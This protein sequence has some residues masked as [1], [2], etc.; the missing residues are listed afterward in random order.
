MYTPEHTPK[1]LS[2]FLLALFLGASASFAQTGWRGTNAGGDGTSWGSANN[3]TNGVPTGS[4]T[5]TLSNSAPDAAQT[6]NLGGDRTIFSGGSIAIGSPG[7]RDYTIEGGK[8]I[9]ERNTSSAITFINNTAGS[10]A[11]TI[12]SDIQFKTSFATN[13]SI[14][15]I[16]GANAS[17]RTINLNG[18]I[19][20]VNTN[21]GEQLHVNSANARVN[22]RG[23]N[24]FFTFK[25]TAGEV[26]TY[27]SLATGGGQLQ[28]AGGTLSL[29]SDL[30][31]GIGAQIAT[32]LTGPLRIRLREEA[33]S[34]ADRTITFF[35]RTGS[36]AGSGTNAYI[37]IIDN[38]NSTGRVILNL[39]ANSATN[40]A[41]HVPINLGSTGL[42][43]FSQP[44]LTYYGPGNS[45]S[46]IISGAGDVEKIGTGTTIL[47]AVNT[48][49][50][51]T[52]VS[53]GALVLGT[54]N[55]IG[56]SA[57]IVNGGTLN[58]SNTTATVASLSISSGSVTGV[59]GSNKLTATTYDLTGGTVSANLGTGT[60]RANSGSA[61]LSGTADA[62]TVNVG[63]GALTL[64][65]AGRLASGAAVT[66]SNSGSLN[67]G[68]N[69]T[70]GSFLISGG[71]LSGSSL[72]TAATYDLTGGT[73]SANLG[74]GTLRANS[75]SATLNGTSAATTVNIGGGALTLGSANRLAS[76][77]TVTVSNSGSLILGGN[78]TVSSLVLSGGSLGGSGV[79]SASTYDFQGGTVTANLGSGT[80]TAST[81]TTLING[82]L[83]GSLTVNSGATLGGSGSIGGA[84][85][86]NGNL[87]PGN[88]PGLL[89]FSNNLT[90]SSSAVTTMEING[91]ER[92]VSYDGIDV[93]GSLIYGGRLTLSLGTTFTEVGQ[94][95]F[96]LFDFSGNSGSFSIVELIGSYTGSLT[97]NSGVWGLNSDNETWSF[98]QG[99][100][101]LT[102]DVVP[103]PSTYAMLVL[104]AA[105]LAAHMI[106]RR[107]RRQ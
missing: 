50:G 97:N 43:R 63:G 75:G 18:N 102:L 84:T 107:H 12:N 10:T 70:V 46:G 72:L 7:N 22:I 87:Q 101:V 92:G 14:I 86:I 30:S 52:T 42:L 90:L 41:Q 73:V 24:S 6:I 68:G 82:S 66:I 58:M 47:T 28:A 19:T 105:G 64:G 99:D 62:T 91:L 55:A 98:S 49:T 1:R 36:S 88:S 104:S 106:R 76:G 60:L 45:N 54:N 31:I 34:S 100:G 67:L 5:I 96:N 57:V 15:T 48:Y 2:A 94:Y 78:Q 21:V 4:N 8:L 11:L 9:L 56:A 85:T 13:A 32:F 61:T 77:S 40:T 83:A 93:G 59:A 3:W 79:L 80:A 26:V 44:G 81:G 27:N 103:E 74:A 16:S 95:T 71:L 29:A 25:I 23:T 37:S 65:S 51:K 39:T 33:L 53:S 17:S 38:S 69:E 20:T 89:T 35:S